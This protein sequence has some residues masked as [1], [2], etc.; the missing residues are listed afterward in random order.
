MSPL[1]LLRSGRPLVSIVMVTYNGWDWPER[2]LAAVAEGT[3]P[4]YEAIVVDNASWDGTGP[5]L[6]ELVDG[7][8]L[9]RNRRNEGFGPAAN[10]GA[11]V[12]QGRYL[13][14][15]N[16]DC[17]V[18]T[19]WLEP[20]IEAL[21]DDSRAGAVIPRFLNPDGTVQEAGS[22]VDRQGWTH[23]FGAGADPAD[24]E[25]RFRRYIDYG[26]AACLVMPRE[27]FERAG[28][29]D[30]RFVPAYCEDV[31]LCFRIGRRGL[32]TVY[33]P[34]STVIHAGAA[35]T[36]DL[37]RARLIERN[38]R[39]LVHSWA[40]RLADRPPLTELDLRPQ[41]L[42]ALR[43]AD[44]PDRILVVTDRVPAAGDPLRGALEDA[45]GRRHARVTL[46]LVGRGFEGV[47]PLLDRGVEVVATADPGPWLNDRRFHYSAVVAPVT[48][49]TGLA[50]LLERT[51]PQA[52]S[53][54][55]ADLAPDRLDR[56]LASV[57]AAPPDRR[58]PGP[59]Y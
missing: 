42:L 46:L 22:A 52:A 40:D 39:L 36:D 11:A 3:P 34:R 44:A 58:P 24:L 13:C 17:L 1:T 55:R 26:S 50:D 14:F 54:D 32:L 5:L 57:G 51:Q 31:D 10:Q 37:R 45:A 4:V 23:A 9:I 53:L 28:G 16:P 21:E 15:L 20:L 33:E 18:R 48:E 27:V 25:H 29:F 59:L 2:S 41:R 56:S 47:E 43:D 49:M 19:G 6:E 8:T 38:R 7:I 12:A 30:P 35:S